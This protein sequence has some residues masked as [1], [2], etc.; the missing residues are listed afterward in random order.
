VEIP[1]DDVSPYFW[2]FI[3]DPYA[4]LDLNGVKIYWSFSR[5]KIPV[6][7]DDSPSG[8]KYISAWPYVEVNN[9]PSSFHVLDNFYAHPE[10]TNNRWNVNWFVFNNFFYGFTEDYNH[11]GRIDR[12]RLQ[13]AFNL[14]GDFTDFRVNVRNADTGEIYEVDTTKGDLINGR[15]YGYAVVQGDRDLGAQFDL[16]SIYV[17]LVEKPYA[18][19]GATLYWEIARNSSLKDYP[20]E[21]TIIG[22]PPPRFAEDQKQDKGRTASTAPPRITYALALPGRNEIFV[23]FSARVVVDS[24]IP[25]DV[26][27]LNST[28]YTVREIIP[29]SG[30]RELLIRLEENIALADLVDGLLSFEI[31]GFRDYA[32]PIENWRD[33][34]YGGEYYFMYPMPKYPQNY[35]YED[36]TRGTATFTFQPYVPVN[37]VGTDESPYTLALPS[38]PPSYWAPR[39]YPSLP[40]NSETGFT[41]GF[42]E[43]R[44]GEYGNRSYNF[45]TGVIAP[46]QHRV[47]DMLISVPPA[48][49]RM[50]QYFVWPVWARYNVP[51]NRLM[52]NLFSGSFFQQDPSDSGIIWEFDG[53][54]FLEERN[55]IMQ[56][57]LQ[58]S[59]RGGPSDYTP[60]L[61]FGA[62]VA[63][64]L[65]G[66]Q[67]RHGNDG[68]W[69][70]G[71][72]NLLPGEPSQ[73][74]ANPVYTNIV[75]YFFTNPNS[76]ISSN[77]SGNLFL[78]EFTA[79]VNGY[80][81][82]NTIDFFFHL[83]DSPKDLFVGRLD[84]LPSGTN[85]SNWYYKVRPF[86]FTVHDVTLQRS[87]VTI[88]NNVI[89]P[90]NG[91]R[92]YVDYRLARGGQVTIQVFT[93]DG[94]MVDIL[95][96]GHRDAG[97]YRAAWDGTNRSGRAVARGMYFIRVV[98][99]DMDELRK[100]MV[101]R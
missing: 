43:Y 36:R 49:N 3:L 10:S 61:F 78:Y 88:L 14:N 71:D 75:P 33:P 50:N 92:T 16:D 65:R 100:V 56:V 70:P 5:Y 8:G 72:W 2:Y 1:P 84:I 97:E 95:Y 27:T 22:N 48:A 35:N 24:G 69:L 80:T 59:L 101:V 55:T 28:D 63:S 83:E 38:S 7:K 37:G 6:P 90:D 25:E 4:K 57:N 91:E 20:T 93:L 18:D 94:T 76:L 12:I 31:T 39:P 85:F 79:G 15:R 34:K 96:R 41:I 40:Q 29:L 23:Q 74:G 45:S 67:A 64:L 82:G 17:Y 77:S 44:E 47:S 51:A 66:T 32:I 26:V 42:P 13:S 21:N 11:N 62:S 60:T 73:N 9:T 81:S 53:K 52:P 46:A 19:T 99:P 87:G 86:S 58:P 98:G 89:N 54:K 30:G 68:L